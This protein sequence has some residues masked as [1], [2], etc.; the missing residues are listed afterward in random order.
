MKINAERE[1]LTKALP[2][3]PQLRACAYL[4][5]TATACLYLGD[6]KMFV[7]FQGGGG[8]ESLHVTSYK[9]THAGQVDITEREELAGQSN[10]FSIL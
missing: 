8:V 1:K 5:S 2:H 9:F 7:K 3:F 10:Q 6:R 4:L